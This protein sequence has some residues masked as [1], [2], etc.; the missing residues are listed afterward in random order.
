MKNTD[1]VA[2][3]CICGRWNQ[4]SKFCNTVEIQCKFKYLSQQNDTKETRSYFDDDTN[5]YK[6]AVYPV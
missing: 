5:Y 2:R 1:L 4:F 3:V 6:R